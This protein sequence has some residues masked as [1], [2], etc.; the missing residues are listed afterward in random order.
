[1]H[2]TMLSSLSHYYTRFTSFNS[3]CVTVSCHEMMIANICVIDRTNQ[4]RTLLKWRIV[5]C[6]TQN[7]VAEFFVVICPIVATQV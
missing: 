7:T 3:A 2:V 5:K 6:K 4:K 1:M